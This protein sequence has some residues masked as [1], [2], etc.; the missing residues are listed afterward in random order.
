MLHR[1]ASLRA[2][3]NK[4]FAYIQKDHVR[5][6]RARVAGRCVCY[7]TRARE[8]VTELVKDNAL[9]KTGAY[10]NGEWMD[11]DSTYEVF[12]PSTNEVLATVANFSSETTEQ[13]IQHAHKAQKQWAALAARDRAMYML[14][15][16]QEQRE[17]KDDLAAIVVAENGKPLYE[18]L[19]EVEEG[20]TSCEWMAAE[21]MRVCGDTYETWDKRYRMVSVKQPI[22]VV[23]CITP[24]NF[25]SY[26]I[27][28]KL[29]PAVA[30]GCT[31]V[32]KPSEE[33]PL[34]AFA[35]AELAHRAG[36]PPGVVNIVSGDFKNIGHALLKS[37]L[38]RKLGFTGSTAVG[39]YLMEQAAGTV[40]RISLELGGNSPFIVFE[41]ADIDKAI[42]GCMKMKFINNGQ[43]CISA[44]RV[45]VHDSIYDEFEAKITEEVKKLSLG[46]GFSSKTTIG[47]SINV[48]QL[49]KVRAH[50][51][52]A[53]QKGGTITIGGQTEPTLPEDKLK[54]GNY[55]APTV[56]REASPD[57]KCFR[58]EQFGPVLP[59]F[60]FKTDEEVVNMAND[61]EY[62]LA[63]YFFTK[64]LKRAWEVAE[65]L[66][67]GM[68]GCNE[69]DML[70]VVVPF[71]GMKHSG[72]GKEN[73]KY[74]IEEFLEHKYICMGI[75]Y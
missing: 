1:Q 59:L 66:E 64:D 32:L 18:A 31:V 67:F 53:I 23:G 41:D 70:N 38:V 65:Q 30:S 3:S 50:I 75:G 17:N 35:L 27:T 22:G 58:E 55:H 34:S 19:A 45:F 21:C 46:S 13:A 52:D 28:R 42:E 56:I 7:V 26:M 49:T 74:G 44:N 9:I 60:R 10:V 25:P 36:I 48:K 14:K 63:G 54:K 40:K 12:D 43:C 16:A 68:V 71:G 6:S 47:P 11:S 4:K 15:W 5:A 72:Q 39:K 20:I 51:A 37:P 24:W 29:A 62:G 73:S 2:I 69:V 8:T 33:T 61:T 57:M